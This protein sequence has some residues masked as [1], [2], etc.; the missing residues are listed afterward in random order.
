M[1]KKTQRFI[2]QF[3]AMNALADEILVQLSIDECICAECWTGFKTLYRWNK[4]VNNLSPE[5]KVA[6]K[7]GTDYWEKLDKEREKHD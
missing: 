5:A 7:K 4:K 1:T 2:G 3:C 6:M